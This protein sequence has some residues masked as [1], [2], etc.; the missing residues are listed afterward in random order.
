MLQRPVLYALLPALTLALGGCLFETSLDAKGGGTMT[1]TTAVE[2]DEFP[3]TKKTMES[4]VVKLKSAEL[5][6][7]GARTDGVF[8][9]EFSDA[10]KLQT[11]QYFRNL[12]VTRAEGAKKGT[13]LITATMK[14]G[15]PLHLPDAMVE[16]FGRE[17]KV[18]VAFPGPVV[19]SN[20]TISGGNT[21]TWQWGVKE[22]FNMPEVTMTATYGDAGAPA[23][24]GATDK[25]PAKAKSGT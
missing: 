17:V 8:K 25:T 6:G 3:R 10:S 7:T 21:V 23:A 20:G 11:T 1:A 2:K 22:F 14:N 15:N 4:S 9:L 13:M 19:E 5:V 24:E 16:R 12:R 18:V